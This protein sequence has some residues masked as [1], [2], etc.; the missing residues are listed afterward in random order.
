MI[1]MSNRK[2]HSY[3]GVLSNGFGR[4]T[5]TTPPVISRKIAVALCQGQSRGHD[6]CETFEDRIGRNGVVHKLER[7]VSLTRKSKYENLR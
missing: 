2:N 3:F 4:V 6:V 1:V 5:Y 7:R